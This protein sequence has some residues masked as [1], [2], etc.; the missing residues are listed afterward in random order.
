[1]IHLAGLAVH[2]GERLA[3]H[4]LPI[5]SQTPSQEKSHD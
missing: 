5:L 1:M 4:I 2:S 3:G